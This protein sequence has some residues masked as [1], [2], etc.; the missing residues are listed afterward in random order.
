MTE[1]STNF[2]NYYAHL[3]R[4]SIIGRFYKRYVSSPILFLC[5]RRFGERLLEIGSGVGNGVLGAFPNSVQG[6]EINPIAVQYCKSIGLNVKMIKADGA[7][8]EADGAYDVCILD[9]VLEHIEDPRI[10]LEECY[11]VTGEKGGL[12]VVVPGIRGYHSDVDHKIFYDAESLRCL[13]NRW[14]L[15]YLFSIPFF[16]RSQR[17]SKLLK[18]YCLVAL[19]KKG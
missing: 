10:T 2:E 11:R 1:N 7:F 16:L 15:T 13:D 18:Q 14:Q 6:L 5:A 19:Y 17:L 3:S 4:T 8:P 9:N 12:V